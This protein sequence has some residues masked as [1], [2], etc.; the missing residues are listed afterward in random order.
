MRHK[1]HPAQIN[2]VED[3][4]AILTPLS[5]SQTS[6]IAQKQTSMWRSFQLPI[7]ER[8]TCHLTSTLHATKLSL[9][10]ASLAHILQ[11]Q[12]SNRIRV[13]RQRGTHLHH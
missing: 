7:A 5:R 13:V 9:L 11:Q 10:A 6:I 1:R 8:A 4:I 3:F 12:F 2:C